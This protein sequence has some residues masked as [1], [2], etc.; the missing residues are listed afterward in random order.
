VL[1]EQ[2]SR[3]CLGVATRV[4][5]IDKGGVVWTGTVEE[6]RAQPDLQGRY[7]QV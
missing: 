3:F 7:L 6:F 2:N 4:A 5:V 1:A